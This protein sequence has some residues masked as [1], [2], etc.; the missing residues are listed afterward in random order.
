MLNDIEE[1]NNFANDNFEAMLFS[2]SALQEGTL[3]AEK[4]SVF[5][6]FLDRY[7]KFTLNITDLNAYNEMQSAGKLGLISDLDLRSELSNLIDAKEFFTE[8]QRTFHRN[9]HL[10][11]QYLDP[12]VEYQFMQSPADSLIAN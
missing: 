5:Q 6:S 1:A 2:L 3:P 7:F 4:D 11:S 10:N 9:S 12:Y 8:V